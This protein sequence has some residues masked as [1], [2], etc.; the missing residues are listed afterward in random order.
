M[1]QRCADSSESP[2]K[3][4]A[5]VKDSLDPKLLEMVSLYELQ[6]TV[7]EVTEDQL[8]QLVLDR[9][10]NVMKKFVPDL[11]GFFCKHLKMDLKEVDIDAR[12]LKY[13]RDFSELIEQ[14]G[15]GRLL[16]V[17]LPGD[18]MFEDRMKLCCKILLGN[19][20]PQVLCNDVQCTSS[21]SAARLRRKTS[22]CFA[23][24]RSGRGHSTG[25]T[26]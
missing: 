9:T 10:N 18:N 4:L 22:S 1:R 24:S 20:E 23:S 3:A 16:V 13:Y 8:V 17:G 21:M 14:H 15:F 26:C 5:S 12:V 2:A 11:D 6:T 19:L 7:D 25:T